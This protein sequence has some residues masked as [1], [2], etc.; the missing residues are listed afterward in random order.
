MPE[1]GHEAF[2]GRHDTKNIVAVACG[3]SSLLLLLYLYKLDGVNAKQERR[4][5]T[6]T[7]VY[8]RPSCRNFSLHGNTILVHAASVPNLH[9]V[10]LITGTL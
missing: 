10:L 1:Q 8:W 2:V 9:V 4:N 3:F 5:N 7:N 6:E